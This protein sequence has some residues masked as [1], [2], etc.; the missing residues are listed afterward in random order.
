MWEVALITWKL[1]VV[2]AAVVP[3]IVVPLKVPETVAPVPNVAAP[4]TPSVPVTVKLP[5]IFWEV[6]LITWKLPVV[7]AAVVPVTVAPDNAV[8]MP[9]TPET[10]W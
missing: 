9:E 6:A 8:N 2:K 4:L 5:L 7:K 1:P 3:V 10:V